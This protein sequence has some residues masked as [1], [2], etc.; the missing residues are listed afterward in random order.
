MQIAKRSA[1]AA[2]RA[3]RGLHGRDQYAAGGHRH[4]RL[5]LRH[6]P[7]PR[8]R[9]G[10]I[11][12]YADEVILSYDSDEAG[13]KATLRSL[14]L[15][16]N[17]PVKVGVLQIPGAKDPDEYIKKYG[18]ERFQALLDGVGNALDFRLKRLRDQY[19]L[20]Q[21]AQRLQYVKEAVEMLAERSNPTEQE[22]YA[23]RLAEETNISKTAILAQLGTAAKRAGGK[24]RREK[25]QRARC[26]PVRWIRSRCLTAQA[27]VRRWALPAPSSGCWR[28]SCGSR[29][30]WNWL[31]S[32]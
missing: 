20:S 23:G 30:I 9:C 8:S 1:V 5:R 26:T 18:P 15:F 32:S 25:N 7:D 19:D 2:V 31:S 13:Q 22:V 21:D 4:C 3:V 24:Y 14:E 27:A 10:I 28:P 12:E 17:S 16:R 11:S 29:G 6:R